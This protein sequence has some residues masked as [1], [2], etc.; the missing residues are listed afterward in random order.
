MKARTA[1][2]LKIAQALRSGISEKPMCRI[3]GCFEVVLARG[4]CSRHYQRGRR[5]GDPNIKPK[6]KS[7]WK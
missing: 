2:Y 1:L 4:L 5:Y 3:L 7:A 6:T